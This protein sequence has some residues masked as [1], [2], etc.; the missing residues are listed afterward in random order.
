MN[1]A[2][3]IQTGA[4]DLAGHSGAKRHVVEVVR[5]LAA[6]EH[7]VR[8]IVEEGGRIRWS[9]PRDLLAF[10]AWPAEGERPARARLSERAVRRLQ[11]T[12]H[13]PYFNFFDSRRFA[14]AICHI[15][16]DCDLVMERYGWMAYGGLL[17]ARR[18]GRPLILEINGNIEAEHARLGLELSRAQRWVSAWLLRRTLHGADALVCVSAPLARQ[19]EASYGLPTERLRVIENGVALERFANL[20]DPEPVR[21]Q[22]G[23]EGSIAI[24]FVG[25]YQPWH[26]V[27]VLFRSFSILLQSV[28]NARLL[29]VGDGEGRLEAERDV[30]SLGIEASVDFLGWRSAEEVAEILSVSDMAVAPFPYLDDRIVGSP[31][32]IYEYMAAG[33]PIVASTAALHDIIQDGRTGVRVPPADP[34]AIA[35][36]CLVLAGDPH[37]RQRLGAAARGQAFAEHGWDRTA[38]RLEALCIEQVASVV[39]GRAG[40]A[41]TRG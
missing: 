32:K 24:A 8:L 7:S 30:A 15:H 23:L 17:A 27:D 21:R 35:A 13:L 14:S 2:Y 5:G 3:V 1:L 40:V 4:P 20:P 41:R 22:L 31:L 26:G 36:A 9:E 11:T 34:E 37:L 29:M 33:L 38:E 16:P 25:T 10:E 12:L 39:A 28:P 18:L 19:I 6:R